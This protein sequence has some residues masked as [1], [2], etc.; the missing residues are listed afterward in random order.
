MEKGR[1]KELKR[2]VVWCCRLDWVEREGGALK[3]GCLLPDCGGAGQINGE[4]GAKVKYLQLGTVGDWLVEG[5]VNVRLTSRNDCIQW[6]E[7]CT[8]DGGYKMPL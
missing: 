6:E 1:E 8:Q 7:I 4:E 2:R 5:N 3:S